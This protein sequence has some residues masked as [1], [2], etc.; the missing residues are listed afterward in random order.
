VTEP[1]PTPVDRWFDAL[2]SPM[3][4]VARSVRAF[5]RSTAPSLT[6]SLKWGQPCFSNEAK[7]VYVAAFREHVNLG[8]YRGAELADPE[9]LLEGTGKGL[10]HVKVRS[11]TQLTLP[12]RRLVRSAATLESNDR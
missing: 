11:T 8:F 2:N 3:A 6:E 5:V 12:L 7:V 4:P 9:R 1:R 10:R